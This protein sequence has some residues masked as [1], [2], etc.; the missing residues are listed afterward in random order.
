MD[1]NLVPFKDNFYKECNTINFFLNLLTEIQ[2]QIEFFEYICEK[3]FKLLSSVAEQGLKSIGVYKNNLKKYKN[4]PS[5]LY[6][7][8]NYLMKFLYIYYSSFKNIYQDY[9]LSLKKNITP[10]KSNVENIRKNILKHSVSMLQQALE[11]NNRNELKKSMKETLELIMINSFKSLFNLYQLMLIYS[12]KKNDIFKN[13]QVKI[14]EKCKSDEIN[15]V[16]NEISER[17]YANK[18]KITYES[19]HF[20][21]NAYKEFIINDENDI[22]KLSKSYL[23]YTYVFIK[24][25]QIRKKL[26]KE[27]RVFLDFIVKNE[28]EK[29]RKVKKVCSKITTH[30]KSLSYLSQGII[31]SWNLIF[32][33]WNSINTNCVNFLQFQEEVLNPKLIKI[34]NDCNEEYKTFQKRWEKYAEIINELRKNYNKYSK[35]DNKDEKIN[36]EKKNS[37]EKLKNYL[38]IDCTDFL[39]NNIPLLR[40]SEIKRA[41]EIKDLSD[42]VK[43][44]LDNLLEQQVENSEKEYDNT[45]SIDLFEEIQNIFE[46]QL[47][48]C[49]VSGPENFYKYIKEKIEKIDF[50]DELAESARLSLAEYYE[51]NDFDEGFEITQGEIENPFGTII[52]DNEEEVYSF[53]V[54][55]NLENSGIDNI[56]GKVKEDEI[57]SIPIPGFDKNENLNNNNNYKT[58]SCN[59]INKKNNIYNL[60]NYEENDLYSDL[61]LINNLSEKFDELDKKKNN[62]INNNKR[63]IDINEDDENNEKNEIEFELNNKNENPDNKN[64]DISFDG[65]NNEN[66]IKESQN[67]N[68]PIHEE[69]MNSKN[70]IKDGKIMNNKVLKSENKNNAI[71]TPDKQNVYY[72]ILG[73]LGLFCLKSLFSS[74]SILSFDSFLNVVILG[75]ISFVFYKTQFQ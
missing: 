44:N 28:K 32:S 66:I 47:E 33:S 42:K 25:I 9:L 59:S 58:P 21:N 13:I 18:Y 74:N 65:K 64:D 14:E 69:D 51:N 75:I 55:K 5:N 62:K 54:Q 46:N 71:K 31:N 22:M 20:G 23:N 73:I 60:N 10:I 48:S 63:N 61:N 3:D 45:A 11:T 56:I 2:S 53:N 1:E 40:E 27:L 70:K 29:L 8:T 50:N 30:T 16:I 36:T 34:V 39:D 7:V 43:T 26:I 72:G 12:K 6:Q 37:G 49:G 24:C 52:K 4:E 68:K 17:S 15:I 67:Y 35:S 38:S 19:L 57:S 41:N